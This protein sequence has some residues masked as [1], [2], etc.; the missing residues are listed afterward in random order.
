MSCGNHG[1]IPR[2]RKVR[3]IKGI[4]SGQDHAG[5]LL[6]RAAGCRTC[7]PLASHAAQHI[8]RSGRLLR[9]TAIKNLSPGTR[10]ALCTLHRKDDYHTVESNLRLPPLPGLFARLDPSR[11]PI[12]KN[13]RT[14][15]QGSSPVARAPLG[16]QG[17]TRPT[18]V[19]TSEE[20][21]SCAAFG[22]PF[23]FCLS[24]ETTEV[25]AH[26]LTWHALSKASLCSRLRPQPPSRRIGLLARIRMAARASVNDVSG[27]QHHPF[28]L[29][30][31]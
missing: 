29:L 10:N 13:P 4:L 9:R 18:S 19:L 23:S 25:E 26:F 30:L 14:A 8:N 2:Q 28:T 11:R 31:L 15:K 7:M 17:K 20:E 27:Q 22:H 21:H 3:E 16:S 24:L 5:T 12:A 1:R 6:E